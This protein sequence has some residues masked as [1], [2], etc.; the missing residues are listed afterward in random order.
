[1]GQPAEAGQ[2]TGQ[3]RIS[4]KVAITPSDVTRIAFDALWIGVGGTLVYQSPSEDDI[5]APPALLNVPNGYLLP[6]GAVRVL[7]TGTTCTNIVGLRV[8]KL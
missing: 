2:I 8:L 1:M 4:S 7:A 5:T 3:G 6:G